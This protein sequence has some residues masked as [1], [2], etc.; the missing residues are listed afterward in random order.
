MAGTYSVVAVAN[1]CT[2]NVA[3]TTVIVNPIPATPTASSNSPVC[4]GNTLNL[5]TPAV[6]GA[7]YAWTGPN[8]FSSA[9]QNPSIAGV[10]AADAGT[11]SVTVTVGGCTSLAGTTTVVVNTTPAAPTASSNSPICAGSSLNLAA[12]V[13]AGATYSW[14]GPNG[15]TS[16]VQNPTIAPA[17]VAATGTY[18]VTATV[19]GCTSAIGTTVVSVNP[20]PATPTVG[21][22]SPL[23]SGNTL[24]LTTTAVA[25]ATYSWTGPNSFSSALQNPTIVSATT[26]ATG[27]YSL[28][29]TVAGCTSA[30]G[31]VTVT[32]NATPAAPIASSNS[33]VCAGTTLNLNASFVAGATYSWTGP[34]SFTSSTQNPSI[35]GIT[36][37]GAGTYSVTATIAGC[38]STF[39]TTTV[40]VNPIPATPTASSNSPICVGATLNLTTTAV[41]GATYSWTGPNGFSSALQ[42]PTIPGATVAATGTYSLTVTVGGCSSAV[43]T[44]AVTVN[45]APAAP[46]VGSNSPVCVGSPLNFTSNFVAGG[47]YSWTGP[48]GFTSSLQNPTIVS[49]TLAAAGTYTLVINNGCASPSTTIAVTVNPT[50][51]APTASSN[52]PICAGSTLNLSASVIAGATYSWTGP[53]G[54]T[55]S[56]QNPS[57]AGVTLAEAGTYSVTATVGGCTSVFGT[58]TVVVNPIPSTPTVSSNSPVCTGNTITLTTPAIAG[59]TYS[60]TGPPAFVSA[61]QNPTRANA[62]LAMAGTYSLTVTVNGCTSGTGTVSVTVN[63]TPIA[64]TASSNSPVCVGSTLNLSAS[65]IAGATYSWTGPNGF[66]SSTQNPSIA[67]ITLTGAGT[68]SVTATVAGCPSSFG[69]TTV[70]VNPIPATPTPSSNSPICVGAT[71]TLTT[72][73]VAGAT[74]SW[75]GP[76]G[77]NSAVQNPSI[78]G[79]TAA[80]AGTYSLTVTVNGC[81]SSAGTVTVIINNPPTAPTVSSNSP[82][83]TGGTLNLAASLVIGSTYSWTGPNGFTSSSQNPSIVG[84]TAAAAGTYTVIVNNGCASSPATTTVVVNATPSAPTAS[85]NSPICDGSTIN[86]SSSL[87][88]G[89]TYSWTGPA[90]FTAATQNATIP[91]ATAVNAGTYSVNVTVNG[92]TSTN[93]TTTV[94]V[95]PIPA[96]PSP[97]SN[98]PVCTGTT[99]S[100]TTSAVA[101][102]TFGWTGPN[103]FTSSL[104]NPNI[105]NVTLA[106]AGTYS[107]T[108]TVLGCTSTAGTVTVVVNATPAAPTASSNSPI[109]DGDPLNLTASAIAGA[110]YSWTGPN[111][112]TSSTQ[113]PTIAPAT[114][115]EAG[116]YSVTATV[117]GCT[118]TFGTTI[119]VVNPVPATP[120][121]ASNGP[122]C[123]GQTLNLSTSAVAGATY[124]W[125]GPNGFTSSVQNPSI[126][127]ATTA[128]SGTYSVTVTVNGCTS[129]AGTVVVLVSNNPPSPVVNSNS[130]VCTGQTIQ[131]NADTI[132]GATYSWNGPNGFSSSQQN[133]TIPGAT[134]A[135]NGTYTVIVFN[136]C[137]SAP[138]TV[139]VV[140]N[141]TPVAPVANSNSPVCEGSTIN[142]TSNLVAGATYAW[143]GPNGFTA[144]TQNTTVPNATSVEAG[145]YSL[146]VTVNGCT[147]NAGTEIVVVDP[148][149]LAG[150]GT[151][152]IV[153]ANNA[154]VSLSAT[155]STGTGTW[156]TSGSGT[157]APSANVLNPTYTPSS[158]D[159][160]AG[161][162]TLTFTTS[163]NGACPA[164]NDQITITFTDA[165][166]ANAGPD[167]TV[168]ANNAGVS[169]NGAVTIAGGGNWTSS[170][171]G[172]FAPS[173]ATLNAT[174]APSAA[175]TAAGTVTLY[176]TTT[177]NGGCLA[178]VDSMVVTIT[179][180]PVAD[181]GLTIFR[182]SNN[183]NAQLNGSSS[184]G[185][186]TWTTSGGGTFSPNAN[187]LN[188]T[189]I[190]APADI[191]AGS[192]FFTLTTTT[193][194]TCNPETDTVSVI[195]TQP[196]VVAAGSDLTICGN[197]ISVALSGSSTTNNG[198]WTTSGSGTFSPNGLNAI[199]FPSSADTAAGTVTLTLTSTNNGGCLAVADQLVLTITDAPIAVAGADIIVC[200]NNALV[201][202]NGSVA[203]STGGTWSTTGSGTFSPSNTSLNATYTP[204]ST[205]TA[206][207]I[208]TIYLT[209]T[210]NG[211]CFPVSDSLIVTFTD[212]PFVIAG[213]TILTCISSPNTPLNGY[214]STGS[215]TWSTSG[216]GTFN[217]NN[218]TLNATYVPST[219]D[220]TAGQ[221]LLVLTSTNNGTCLSED[222]TVLIIFAPVPV[223][224]TT[225]D[226]TVCGNNAVVIVGATSTTNS[227]TWSTSGSGTFAPSNTNLNPTY[228][229]SAADTAAG[230][231]VLTFT[232]T[233]GCTPMNSTITITITDAPFVIAGPDLFTCAN[234][235]NAQVSGATIGGATTTGIWTTSGGG[236]FSPSNTD[237][238]PTYL[239]D[240]A[241]IA[242]GSIT[243]VLTSTGNGLCNPV[244]DTVLLT[245]TPPPTVAAGADLVACANNPVALSGTV[246][247]GNGTGI[248]STPNGS[249]IFSP[250]ATA[251]NA[252]YTPTNADTMIS[253]VMII[254]TSTNNG[255]CLP[256]SDT[257][258]IIVNPGPEVTA[259]ADQAVC[260]NNAA[261]TLN[262]T[263]YLSTGIVWTTNGDG[264]FTPDSISTA[265]TY[266]P[267][268]I[269]TANG[270]V[271]I[272]ITSTGNG[273]CNPAVDSM[274]I[275]ITDAPFVNAG[276]NQSICSGIPS[277]SLN[278]SVGGGA[279]T[280]VWT[281]TGSGTFS[282]N[283]STLNATYTFSPAD[284][285]AGTVTMVLTSTNNGLCLQVADTMV[286]SVTPMPTVFAGNDTSMCSG[287]T[288]TLGGIVLGG[289][290]TGVWTTSGDGTFSPNDSAL[291]AVYLPG[292]LDSANG[293]VTLVLDA[294][295]SCLPE[296]DTIMISIIVAPVVDAGNGALICAGDIVNLNGIVTNTT[297]GTWTT[298][299]DGTF[300]PNATTLNATY[301]P[302]SNDIASGNA[303]VTL[304][305]DSTGFCSSV[306]D[307]ITILINSKPVAEFYYAGNCDNAATVF[308]DSSTNV[309]GAITSWNWT[310][311]ITQDTVQHP[312]YIF[313][314]AG[315]HTVT[316][317]VTTAAGCADTLTQTVMVNASPVA[318]YSD[319]TQCPFNGIYA[320]ESFITQGSIA[321]WAWNFGDSTTATVQNPTHVYADS[322]MYIVTL[323][324]TSDSGCVSVFSDTSYIALCSETLT[325]P[326]LPGAFTPNGDS[327]NDVFL[328]RGGPMQDMT[329]NVY[330]EWDNLIFSSTSQAIGWDGT[331]KG[332]PQPAGT[333]I[334]TLTGTTVDGT[335]VNIYGSVT[336][337][338]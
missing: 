79:A 295:N 180:A 172:T 247:G 210:G 127:A 280:G 31:T 142:L 337:L 81:T 201:T 52:S 272:Y 123:V 25:G 176:L 320:D 198:I 187:T 214:S 269:D 199:Y 254:L 263:M 162:V 110:T 257:L 279:S 182:C 256:A 322:G 125:N 32:V 297:G 225:P 50:P 18:S 103:G 206:A 226:Q 42:N 165:P 101:G 290:G 113:N 324:V 170:G 230:M 137:A 305:G 141:P 277:A 69:T 202:L 236:F 189:Y 266:N 55:S 119:V 271:T 134:A 12:S 334:W 207:G 106:A 188:A 299:G 44:V 200:G 252:S 308:A 169:L 90:G 245:I 217:P 156:T 1:G 108:V 309:N 155:S 306:S 95:N 121:P 11:Y 131:L 232:S 338:R 291:N 246:T 183:P 58:T 144:T 9:I 267:G 7:T 16:S 63:A 219:A 186:G 146:T 54:F 250:S 285:V 83:C 173:S 72:T 124:S 100:L 336:I 62:T 132:A 74:Y 84:V 278:G 315:S 48:N 244:A 231:V 3:T 26:A 259:G 129:A 264:T 56:I 107:L 15:F 307:V 179:D 251:L 300:L 27:T 2:S 150:A 128:A 23:C 194:G 326:V 21:S 238:N 89:A 174:Y 43:G 112:Y 70:V 5:S 148:T 190:P 17:T 327:H 323:A 143:S 168:C 59:A 98:S 223:V 10:T 192:V 122:I 329:L 229:P 85:S 145:T 14:T 152:Q 118:G 88:A 243:L 105:T 37:A 191:A 151:S 20:V 262:G 228:T 294:T 163:N 275:T 286:I 159:T 193:N 96:T 36:A 102:A 24:T 66:T 319:T 261:V 97:S 153:C 115:A 130:P 160:A 34:N 218:A 94:V 314:P 211:T 241:D 215:A 164:D 273:L 147:S 166:T 325:D 136:G 293:A 41:A 167:Q 157:F 304:T 46:V 77:F 302:G 91:G 38:T 109:C 19:G 80:D 288:I 209:T 318:L 233:N 249:G 51:A 76:N 317:I 120:A 175:D 332:K 49:V 296:N 39:G 274:V 149:P 33:P 133:P 234:S 216:T 222:D 204:T 22:N 87:V 111:A 30:T 333:Y 35:A 224:T 158:T 138:A 239:P 287:N 185:T 92:C 93:A 75:T 331:Y 140:V 64:P 116:T 4:T 53:N 78:L 181:A 104:Q 61:L 171:T 235:P 253:P 161:S 282:P 13:I 312:S 313:S 321:S 8:S 40:V 205:D 316:L 65:V 82:V 47:I 220:T 195:F 208:I 255:G 86:L 177:S 60:W 126:V 68:Y 268:P 197:Q 67:G 135:A 139:T 99:L 283:D 303:T 301:V 203:V 114:L 237:L 178:T 213:D 154:V 330:N 45:S 289:S 298:S 196:P 258:F 29:V 57:I 260:A 311:D 212:A 265:T 28:T 284:T 310:F 292:P 117:A 71:L 270:S 6:V 221:V 227:G 248:W 184:T 281:T 73:A 276:P 335:P 242:A 240:A 328:V